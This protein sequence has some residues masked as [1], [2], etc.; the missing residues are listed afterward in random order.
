MARMSKLVNGELLNKNWHMLD[1]GREN[2]K[3]Y[4]SAVGKHDVGSPIL[5]PEGLLEQ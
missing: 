3:N 2:A 4:S 1:S 5:S